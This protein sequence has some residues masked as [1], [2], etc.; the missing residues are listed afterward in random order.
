MSNGKS[1]ADIIFDAI[2]SRKTTYEFTTSNPMWRATLDTID[3]IPL[4]TVDYSGGL[5]ISD[6]YSDGASQ[7]ESLKLTVRFLS[8]EIQA[9]S[10]KI[11]VFQK[12]CTSQITCT[13]KLIKSKI[14]DELLRSILSKAAKLEKEQNIKK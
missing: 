4:T 1:N 2:M 13:T 14:S 10:L 3:F 12:N 7:N 9:N 5:I 8:N 6:W 11:Q